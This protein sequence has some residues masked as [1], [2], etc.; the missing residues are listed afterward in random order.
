MDSLLQDWVARFAERTPDAVAVVDGSESFSY[1][2]LH[3]TSNRIAR[4]LLTYGLRP[5]DRVAI[6]APRS[7][8]AILAI[9]GVLK[10]GGVYVPVD[11]TGPLVRTQRILASAQ[12]TFIL[13]SS[14]GR[15]LTEQILGAEPGL[16][17]CTGWLESD[18][19]TPPDW[20]F[21][22]SEVMGSSDEPPHIR[23]APDDLAHILFTSGSTGTPKGVAI[24]HANVVSL[25]DWAVPY[26]GIEPSDRTSGHHPLHFDLSTF[27][28]FGSFAAGAELHLVPPSLNLL[29]PRLADFIRSQEL[30]QWFSVPSTLNYLAQFDALREGDMPKLR[31][32]LWCGEVLPRATL[33]YMM[34]RLPHASFTNLYGPTEATI[35]SSFY[36]VPDGASNDSQPIPIGRACEGEELHILEE[37]LRPTRIGEIGQLYISGCGLSPGYWRDEEKTKAAFMTVDLGSG[38]VR[39]YRT[40]D[41]AW[42][43]SDGVFHFVGREDS[44]IKSR[45]YR[46]EL[47]EIDAAI[48]ALDG[49]AQ[50][51]SVAVESDGFEGKRI[52]CALVLMPNDSKVS[53]TQLRR[54]LRKTLPGYMLPSIWKVMEELPVNANGKIDRP[55]IRRLLALDAASQEKSSVG[56][57]RQ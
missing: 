30:T 12:P 45:G 2:D 31:R 53:P 16:R 29:A 32:V 14:E 1:R 38:P 34:E 25:I 13:V 5:N 18:E 44:Q 27:D 48:H 52:G 6:L 19:P 4:V 17:L 23:R 3:T 10:A 49:V 28:M 54:E 46:I 56:S 57:K 42:M 41:L 40:G 36:R 7:A 35:A 8:R 11:I 9:H 33:T 22:W 21:G 26:F 15:K 20:D 55:A 47:G 37:D 39:V 24:N 51:A 43:D 50:C